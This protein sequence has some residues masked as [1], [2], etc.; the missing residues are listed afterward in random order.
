MR[1]VFWILAF[2]LSAPVVEA[3]HPWIYPPVVVQQNYWDNRYYEAPRTYH[4]QTHY[5]FYAPPVRRRPM[6]QIWPD[7]YTPPLTTLW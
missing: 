7:N 6:P 3:Q 4:Y 2:C 5:H 1:R